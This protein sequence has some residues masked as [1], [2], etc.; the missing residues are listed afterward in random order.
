M[1]SGR[2]FRHAGFL[3]VV[4]VAKEIYDRLV[5]RADNRR[6]VAAIK[7]LVGEEL[8]RN[9]VT[10]SALGQALH[11]IE[12]GIDDN[13]EVRLSSQ[14][15]ALEVRTSSNAGGQG[16]LTLVRPGSEGR[17]RPVRDGRRRPRSGALP[18]DA[19]MGAGRLRP[20]GRAQRPDGPRGAILGEQGAQQ[21]R[22]F[23]SGHVHPV[24]DLRSIF[25]SGWVY[26]APAHPSAAIPGPALAA[27]L[28]PRSLASD[29]RTPRR[30]RR[31]ASASSARSAGTKTWSWWNAATMLALIPSRPAPS[32]PRRS[33]PPRQGSNGPRG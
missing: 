16:T 26:C 23:A 10:A 12:D 32:P 6:R 17:A 28:T 30:S 29:L 27:R 13:C 20:R 5:R 11:R 21:L 8:G 9:V 2:S 22:T 31:Q 19:E 25:H 3:V 1:P 15:D 33:A 7:T 4:L 18:A 24:A 14:S